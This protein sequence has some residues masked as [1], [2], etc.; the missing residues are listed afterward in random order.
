MM[1]SVF[2]PIKASVLKKLDTP[3]FRPM[4]GFWKADTLHRK[5]EACKNYED[6]K[7]VMVLAFDADEMLE[8][9]EDVLKGAQGLTIFKRPQSYKPRNSPTA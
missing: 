6:L 8:I 9:L 2:L 4:A 7:E 1:P 3:G 5:A